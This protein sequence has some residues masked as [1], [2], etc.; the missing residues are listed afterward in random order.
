MSAAKNGQRPPVTAI[1]LANT[2]SCAMEL[3]DGQVEHI[4]RLLDTTGDELHRARY[5]GRA[6]SIVVVTLILI[7]G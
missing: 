3:A 4:Q 1:A 7:G 2:V 5:W 6:S